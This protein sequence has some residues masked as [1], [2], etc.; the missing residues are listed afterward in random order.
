VIAAAAVAVVAVAVASAV[1]AAASDVS[2][3]PSV[4]SSSQRHHSVRKRSS[5]RDVNGHSGTREGEIHSFSRGA[6]IPT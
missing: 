1:A 4:S 6:L 3:S 2:D 5:S